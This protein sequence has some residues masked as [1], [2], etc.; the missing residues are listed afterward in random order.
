MNKSS[1]IDIF[2]AF[3]LLA[4]STAPSHAAVLYSQLDNPSSSG[5]TSQEFEIPR[6]NLNTMAADDFVITGETW[7]IEELYI[8]GSLSGS[9][10]SS[11]LAAGAAV[12]V[13][14]Y[15]DDSGKPGAL[16]A[17]FLNQQFTEGD[18]GELTITLSIPVE[19]DS[20]TWWLS[21]VVVLDYDGGQWYWG[22][23][24]VQTGFAA[25]W[26]NPGNGFLTGCTTWTTKT[27]CAPG[28][29][30]LP[31]QLFEIRGQKIIQQVPE[32]ATLTLMGIGLAGIGVARNLKSAKRFAQ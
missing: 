23:R 2:L 10:H 26:Q 7:K 31:D 25:V 24:T 29:Q 6:S 15:Q 17:S 19:L 18:P 8:P 3:I 20:G 30:S 32:P 4:A 27:D 14:F 13:T 5:I 12:N 1:F 16:Y 21:V 9:P 22:S 11:L 28:P